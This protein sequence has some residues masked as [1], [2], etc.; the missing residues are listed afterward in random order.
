MLQ[1]LIPLLT[2]LLQGGQGAKTKNPSTGMVEQPLNYGGRVAQ[3][4]GN[5]FGGTEGTGGMGGSIL[6]MLLGSASSGGGRKPSQPLSSQPSQS[7]YPM[8]APGAGGQQNNFQ[9]SF[10]RQIILP[11]LIKNMR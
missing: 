6:G 2:S 3:G 10:F 8:G 9:D 7:G 4:Y 5:M 1:F 11:M